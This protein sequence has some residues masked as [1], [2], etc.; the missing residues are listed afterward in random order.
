MARKG[1]LPRLLLINAPRVATDFKPLSPHSGEKLSSV[2]DCP[3]RRE[4]ALLCRRPSMMPRLKIRRLNSAAVPMPSATKGSLS[5]IVKSA[6]L[7]FSSEPRRSPCPI[8]RAASMVTA[9]IASFSQIRQK[10]RPEAVSALNLAFTNSSYALSSVSD[11][12]RSACLIFR[13]SHRP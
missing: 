11:R 10:S 6:S 7:S 9:R 5:S 8:R 13:S 4:A 3:R 2:L 12:I 1:P